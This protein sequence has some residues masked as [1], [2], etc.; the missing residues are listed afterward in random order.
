MESKIFLTRHLQRIDDGSDSSRE[1]AVRWNTTDSKNPN[2]I[3]NP[4][5]SD[6]ADRH[7]SSVVDKI[8]EPINY[9]VSSPF[10]R[11]MQT[12]LK[13]S[14]ELIRRGNIISNIYIDFGLSEIVEEFNFYTVP[15]SRLNIQSVYDFSLEQFNQTDREKFI[16]LDSNPQI[17]N[18]ETDETYG[19]RIKQ[20]L[21]KI[22][23]KFTN[24]NILVVSHAYSY[25]PLNGK[26][27]RY[28]DLFYI[29]PELF[30]SGITG[31]S[32]TDKLSYYQEKYLKYKNKYLELKNLL[33]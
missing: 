5:L 28:L 24:S 19:Q 29:K 33:K 30:T 16:I 25:V 18:F 20:T 12:A 11:C 10:L 17:I 2:F 13:I 27:L 22:Y 23:R 8:T 14:N 4:Y 3:I 9:I 15:D 6:Y 1:F 26:E 32:Q 7:V 31:I 21:N